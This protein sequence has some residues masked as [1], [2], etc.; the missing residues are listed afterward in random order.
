MIWLATDDDFVMRWHAVFV[1]AWWYAV[2]LMLCEW[3]DEK[4]HSHSTLNPETPILTFTA[5]LLRW[6]WCSANDL[7]IKNTHTQH[8]TLKPNPDVYGTWWEKNKH[9]WNPIP[10]FITPLFAVM[11]FCCSPLFCRALA[12]APSAAGPADPASSASSGVAE[13]VFSWAE[14]AVVNAWGAEMRGSGSGGIEVLGMAMGG[15]GVAAGEAALAGV[16]AAMAAGDSGA[17]VAAAVE[18]GPV[19]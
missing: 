7:M 9:S 8:S 5:P 18:H 13:R 14:G 15:G 16:A 1:M 10:T 11:L 12:L 6:C 4:K 19:F 3:L 17:L 2:M